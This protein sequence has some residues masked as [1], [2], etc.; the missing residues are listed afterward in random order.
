M[1][2]ISQRTFG[3]P[4]VLEVIE[5]ERPEPAP[6]EVLVRVLAAGVNPADWK[7][8]AGRPPLFGDPPFVLGFDLSGVVERV[9]PEVTRF[10]PGDEV[11]GMPAPP[12]GTYAEYV[13]APA[14]DLVPKP[15]SL[16]HVHAGALPAVALTAWQALVAIA[17]VRAGQRVLVHAAAGG[18]GHVAVQIA[19]ARGAHVIGTARADK[20]AFLRGLDVDEPI[21]YT[22]EDFAV[23][24][25]DVDVV[26]DLIGGPYGARSLDTLRPGGLLVAA[27]WNDPGVEEAEV[28]RRGLRYAPVH[29]APSA[30]DLERINELVERGLLRVH[31]D[32]VLPLEDA[33]K[34]HEM[35]ESGR[36]RGKIVLTG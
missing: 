7:I 1:R 23:A 19:K 33:G 26:F 14:A 9:G 27:V 25:R 13:A 31:V 32:Q 36:V 11:Y 22:T 10:Q 2:A 16:D 34:A 21:D 4:E 8:R 3:G 28:E 24:A 18:L 35:S 29:V 17:D 5:V 12:A 30:G 15:R 20:H 6:G